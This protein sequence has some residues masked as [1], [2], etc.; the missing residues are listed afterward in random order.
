MGRWF[1]W[2]CLKTG[3]TDSGK[4]EEMIAHHSTISPKCFDWHIEWIGER[5]R[6]IRVAT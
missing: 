2:K 4:W 1:C 6:D 5:A 3:V